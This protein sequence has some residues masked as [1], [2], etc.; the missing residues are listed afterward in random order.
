MEKTP[1]REGRT[2]V[3]ESPEHNILSYVLHE[4][5]IFRRPNERKDSTTTWSSSPAAPH[6]TAHCSGSECKIVY[7]LHLNISSWENT[8]SLGTYISEIQ[9]IYD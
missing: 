9:M 8:V 2:M 1:S 6:I 5:T 4:D 3:D 7:I